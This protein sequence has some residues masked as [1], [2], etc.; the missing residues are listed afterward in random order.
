MSHQSFTDILSKRQDANP[1][2]LGATHLQV[3]CAPVDISRDKAGYLFGA[4]SQ[5]QKEQEQRP[6]AQVA[7]LRSF[8]RSP[9]CV[10]LLLRQSAWQ[11]HMLPV[12]NRRQSSIPASWDMF[13]SRQIAEKAAQ[14]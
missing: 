4:Q 10:Y 13:V 1:R 2:G 3:A 9:K 11:L 12:G 8:T 7:R 6:V 5:A 14:H